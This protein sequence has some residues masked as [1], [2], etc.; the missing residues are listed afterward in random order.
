MW[1]IA[2]REWCSLLTGLLGWSIL[3][4]VQFILAWV[5]AVL[6]Y[7]FTQ[8]DVQAQLLQQEG[9]PGMSEL[10]LT[11]WFN[12]LGF[13][14]V[15]ITPF[16][17][18]RL[19]AEE[20]R[21]H[22]LILLLSAPLSTW[23][24][25]LGK[26]IGIWGFITLLLLIAM[27]MPL[28]LLFGTTLD[29]GQLA[30]AFLAAWL[31]SAALIAVGLYLSIRNHQ[32]LVA[33]MTTLVVLLLLWILDWAGGDESALFHYLSLQTHYQVLITGLVDS[34][35]I[36]YYIWVSLFFLGLSYHQLD[37]ERAN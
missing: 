13:I 27:L 10:I 32:P 31:L 3:A 12:W 6:V 14:L 18:M 21:Q 20:R 4:L 28:S 37:S 34:T 11:P 35:H 8:S 1:I 16:L 22:S 36:L 9:M 33:A 30:A 17:T 29:M 25:V 23:Q 26:F 19:I 2:G 15:F 5:F 24:I 7:V